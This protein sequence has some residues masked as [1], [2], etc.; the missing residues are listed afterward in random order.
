MRRG[1]LPAR[2]DAHW[3]AG[4]YVPVRKLYSL[5]RIYSHVSVVRSVEAEDRK[6]VAAPAGW[7]FWY[8]TA[9]PLIG[10]INSTS[11]PRRL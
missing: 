9:N 5:L 11:S 1:G 8:L 4:L 3:E 2:L 7:L 10:E 6:Y